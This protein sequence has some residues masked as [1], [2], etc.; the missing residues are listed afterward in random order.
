MTLATP[1]TVALKG[2]MDIIGTIVAMPV[3][4]MNNEIVTR[5]AVAWEEVTMRSPCPSFH[6]PEELV[7]VGLPAVEALFANDDEDE[8][9]EM[10][11]PE[12][13]AQPESEPEALESSGEA[14]N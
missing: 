5:C 11:A 13:E 7:Y 2:N 1:V 3:I 4:V 6:A 8:D 14:L 12:V 10:E 9:E